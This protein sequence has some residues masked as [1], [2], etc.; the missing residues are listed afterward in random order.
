[1]F[2]WKNEKNTFFVDFQIYQKN[3]KNVENKRKKHI[4]WKEKNFEK[5][6]NHKNNIFKKKKKNK[7]SKTQINKKANISIDNDKDRWL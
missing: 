6:T 1:M 5:T 4:F 7:K 3:V 2:F